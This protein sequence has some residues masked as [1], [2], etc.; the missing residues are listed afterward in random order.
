MVTS[1]WADI[2]RGNGKLSAGG[3]VYCSSRSFAKLYARS[4]CDWPEYH[5]T[6]LNLKQ[7]RVLI[8][9]DDGVY[10]R[11]QVLVRSKNNF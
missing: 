7:A 2:D 1:S 4:S 10:A 8:T 3:W 6:D 5:V 9:N 11:S